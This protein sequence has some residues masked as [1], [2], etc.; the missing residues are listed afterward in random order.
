VGKIKNWFINYSLFPL[1]IFSPKNQFHPNI[2]LI[3][4]E[5]SVVNLKMEAGGSFK[6]AKSVPLTNQS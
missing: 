2:D 5:G 4:D 1:L 3:S 6:L